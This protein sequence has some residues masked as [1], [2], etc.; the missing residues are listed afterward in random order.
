MVYCTNV[1]CCKKNQVADAKGV[2]RC[3]KHFGE[4]DCG[5]CVPLRDIKK[6][7]T[8]QPIKKCGCNEIAETCTNKYVDRTCKNYK[9]IKA[10]KSVKLGKC[11]SCEFN[12]CICKPGYYRHDMGQCVPKEQCDALFKRR[13]EICCADPNEEY[14]DSYYDGIDKKCGQR[15]PDIFVKGEPVQKRPGCKCGKHLVRNRCSQCVPIQECSDICQCTNPCP[16][17]K[18]YRCVN[19]CNERSFYAKGIR[20][21]RPCSDDHCI[22]KCDC[23]LGFLS[24]EKGKCLPENLERKKPPIVIVDPPPPAD[25]TT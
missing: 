7:C 22:W 10:G 25:D 4:N 1:K 5:E 16:A 2:C 14:T 11:D 19:L 6:S 20:W 9:L 23:K 18:E 15:K 24:D 12:K 13:P 8:R 21:F 17:D 3:R